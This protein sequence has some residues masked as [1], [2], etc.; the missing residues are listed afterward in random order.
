MAHVSSP[1]EL[2]RSDCVIWRSD[3]EEVIRLDGFAEH[4]VGD[5]EVIQMGTEADQYRE[6]LVQVGFRKVGDCAGAGRRL[7]RVTVDS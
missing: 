7:R 1:A 6:V 5:P 2:A 4:L 3:T